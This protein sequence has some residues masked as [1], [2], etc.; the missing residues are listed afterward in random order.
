MI[1]NNKYENNYTKIN[2]IIRVYLKI[3][4]EKFLASF[5]ENLEKYLL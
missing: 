2:V 5:I 3:I 4:K 1:H